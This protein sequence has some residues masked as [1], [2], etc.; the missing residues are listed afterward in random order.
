MGFDKAETAPLLLHARASRC[1][2][3]VSISISDQIR[4]LDLQVAAGRVSI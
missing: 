3:R 2:A 4:G 1:A